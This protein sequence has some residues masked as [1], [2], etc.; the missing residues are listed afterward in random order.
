MILFYVVVLY[1]L[2]YYDYRLEVSKEKV[3]I[4]KYNLFIVVMLSVFSYIPLENR[5]GDSLVEYKSIY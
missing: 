1:K 4:N 2:K 5:Q 3:D